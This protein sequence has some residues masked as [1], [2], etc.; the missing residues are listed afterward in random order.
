MPLGRGLGARA[1]WLR[2]CSWPGTRL[3]PGL[4]LWSPVSQGSDPLKSQSSRGR[5]QD[6]QTALLLVPRLS[7]VPLQPAVRGQSPTRVTSDPPTLHI[8]ASSRMPSGWAAW[9]GISLAWHRLRWQEPLQQRI[10]GRALV[11]WG[12][13]KGVL[14]SQNS[15][16]TE[17][18][19]QQQQQE[20]QGAGR[21]A[22]P[23]P[24]CS[25]FPRAPDGMS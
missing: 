20:R 18:R 19:E 13:W 2:L 6:H 17:Y 9:L 24:R 25:A 8:K 10:L 22:S 15:Q 5:R 21:M 16:E 12:D 1:P 3:F 23:P 4:W 11:P 14:G 7:A